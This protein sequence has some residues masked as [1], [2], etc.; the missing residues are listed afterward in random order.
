MSDRLGVASIPWGSLT[1]VAAFV[2]STLLVQQAFQPLRPVE[3][4]RA[5]PQQGAEL[6]V[7]ARLWGDPFAA[8]RRFE[9]DR[10]TRCDKLASSKKI[11]PAALS[12]SATGA[13]V[14][15]LAESVSAPQAV[16]LTAAITASITDAAAA[17]G[18]SASVRA[19]ASAP[20][21]RQ[22]VAWAA[23]LSSDCDE[24]ATALRRDPAQLMRALDRNGNQ[25]LTESLVVV[26][27]VPGNAFVGAEES[28]R[29][30]RYATLAGLQAQ[31]HVPRDA[32]HFG[33][34]EVALGSAGVGRSLRL[35]YELLSRQPTLRGDV[36]GDRSA[37][38]YAQVAVV[39]VDE[40]ALP[41]RK[42]DSVAAL[43]GTLLQTPA[44]LP[45]VLMR[46]GA[47]QANL[48]ALA[49]IGPSTSDALR[50]ALGD[51]ELAAS[52]CLPPRAPGSGDPASERASAR[53]KGTAPEVL[54]GYRLLAQARLFNASA[55]ASKNVM[56]ELHD[57]KL[58]TYIQERLTRINGTP[59]SHKIDYRRTMA[60][61]DQVLRSMVIELQL[62]LPADL[63]RRVVLLAERD[64]L[65]AQALVSELRYRLTDTRSQQYNPRLQLETRYFFRGLDGA[66]TFDSAAERPGASK[67]KDSSAATSAA[68][69]WPEARDQL[70]Y[71]RRL[72]ISLKTSEAEPGAAGGP[73]GAIG[74]LASDVHDKL[75]VLQALHESFPDK[76]FFTTDLDARYV[77]P[78]TLGYTRNLVVAS[79]LPLA[80]ADATVQAGAPPFRDVYQSAVFLAAQQAACRQGKP[81]DALI[82]TVAEAIRSPSVYEI[83]RQQAVPVAGYDH[84]ERVRNQHVVHTGVALPMW[85]LLAG[86]LLFWPST[87]AL[88]SVQHW[89]T[90]GPPRQGD[91]PPVPRLSTALLAVLHLAVLAFALGSTVEFAAP[92]R[93][94]LSG[95]LLLT[96]LVT[97]AA[98]LLLLGRGAMRPLSANS[99]A[100]MPRWLAPVVGG[101]LVAG[102]ALW[103]AWPATSDAPCTECEPAAWLEGVSAWPSHAVHLLALVALVCIL[104]V[105]WNRTRER[106][107]KDTR[108]LGLDPAVS[109]KPVAARFSRDWWLQHTI[110][111][112]S[113]PHGAAEQATVQIATLWP[114]LAHRAK[115]MA[116]IARTLIGYV[117]TIGL[118]TGLF[119]ALSDGRVPEVPVRGPD[120]RSLVSMT[121]YAVLALLP[122]LMVAVADATLL[123]QRFIHHLDHGRSLYPDAT[124]TRFA[125]KLGGP[126]QSALWLRR[127]A[128]VPWQ[129]S[130]LVLPQRHTL[131]DNW[132]DVQL[133]GRRTAAVA[134][135]IVGPLVLVALLVVARSRL[136]D[137][138]AIT[139]PVA[140]AICAYLV[141]LVV[142]AV[143]LKRAAEKAREKALRRM[144]ADL[145]WLMGAGSDWQ[146]LVEPLKRLIDEVRNNQ[147]GAFAP[148]FE[149]PL[150]KGLMVPLGG[151]GGA[152]LFDYLL[153]AR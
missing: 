57:Q 37:A 86:G 46:N 147:E 87:P 104:D 120:H 93:L 106:F 100:P 98:L 131:F 125:A 84:G 21:Q 99:A 89:L 11:R 105:Q 47:P 43:L 19:R 146:P 117:V 81:C 136:F 41:P 90:G 27:M 137:N 45:A 25:D 148:L 16:P 75:L 68:V 39:W 61:D 127:L 56:I 35:P 116:R 52:R 4:E 92:G 132:I 29:R 24:D 6:E 77:H 60:T 138:W 74:L 28:R 26:V 3:K 48:P 69:E 76:V 55:T 23:S 111:S 13:T 82:A 118:M 59:A 58:E 124:L 63:P 122:M 142:L 44:N 121:L 151:I 95:I 12:A 32:E 65:Y 8:T 20:D 30:T 126:V 5:L 141:W 123:T 88:R 17:P 119:F 31:G 49:L 149:Q 2:S 91:G 9:A 64:S 15:A 130:Y 1:V 7:E 70:D 110:F 150:F 78:R 140:L 53:C 133:I 135:L 85:L 114:A 97:G 67:E 152:Q 79:S 40:T 62:R 115:A 94:G 145:L 80:F 22:P 36:A 50:T 109:N 10:N 134:P 38:S 108:W 107:D 139:M 143:M 18:A 112:W 72:A 73:I 144:Q 129:R 14:L 33:L 54:D 96:A 113:T 101:L 66:T 51:L 34:L 102:A 128:A 153:L 42:L 83:G 71:L 103:V